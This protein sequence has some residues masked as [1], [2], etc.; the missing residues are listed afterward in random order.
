MTEE[1]RRRRRLGG[2]RK[3]KE[4]RKWWDDVLNN[5]CHA[6]DVRNGNKSRQL[7]VC[8]ELCL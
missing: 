8:Q 6:G 4:G 1:G 3:R 5:V 2:V 7:L